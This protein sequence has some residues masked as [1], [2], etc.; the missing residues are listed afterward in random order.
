MLGA[1]VE[2]QLKHGDALPSEACEGPRVVLRVVEMHHHL[3]A[4]VV[5]TASL[6]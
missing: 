2:G 1:V 4:K 5:D 3:D 6:Y